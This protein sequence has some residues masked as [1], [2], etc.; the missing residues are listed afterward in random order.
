MICDKCQAFFEAF[1]SVSNIFASA[2]H[3]DNA[4]IA[5]AH[6]EEVLHHSMRE[7]RVTSDQLCPICRSIL[8]SPTKWELR[9]L[10]PDDDEE[11]DVVLEVDAKNT[12]F[13][14]LFVTFNAAG[15]KIGRLPR[16]M[17]A[18]CDGFIQDEEL[19][20]ALGHTAQLA[21]DSTGS[22]ASLELAGYWLKKCLDHHDKC[23]QES[24]TSANS[25]LPT[26]LI[27]VA[28]DTIRLIETK[29]AINEGNDR[30]YVSLSHCWGRVQIIRTLLKNIDEHKN[31]IDPKLLS[32]TFQEAIHVTRKLGFRY[33]WIDSL[34]IIQDEKNDWEAEAGTM[35]DVYRNATLKIAAAP[36]SGGDAGCFQARDGLIQ[37]PFLVELPSSPG[38][39][40]VPPLYGRSWVL[41]EQLL[42]PRMLIFDGFQVRWQCNTSHGSERTP[43]GG[44]SRHIGH[45][46]ALRAGIFSNEEFFSIPDI[47][48]QEAAAKYQLQYWMYTV[49]DYTHRGMTKV[50]D[51]LVA[52]EG[53]AQALSRHTK[54][55]YYAG[56]WEQDFWLGLLW[57]VAHENEFT[58]EVPE[59][60]SLEHNT[61]VRHEAAIAPSWSWV[62]VTVPVVYP[63]P[64][65]LSLHRMCDVLSV[66]VAGTPA[67][68]SGSLKLTGHLRT[69]YVDAIY[70][71]AIR[72]AAL[73]NPHM[74]TPKPT[75]A[76]HLITYRGRSFHPND[77]FVFSDTSPDTTANRLSGGQNWRLIRGTFRPDELIPPNTQ[78]TFL[79]IA[80]WHVGL[81][82]AP[83]TTRT[84]RPHDPITIW[85]IALVPTGATNGEFRRVGYAVWEDCAWYGYMCGVRERPGRG[86]EREAGWKG[87]LAGTHL[88]KMGWGGEEVGGAHKHE[89]VRG[90]ETPEL[91]RYGHWVE[92][93]ERMV[94][95]V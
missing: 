61:H 22:D 56:L 6:H 91:K 16:R 93:A 55:K 86:V 31:C 84:H 88:E 78:L 62:S 58:A 80:Q 1:F 47:A 18:V 87:M 44:L 14:S 77:F 29:E 85:S 26:R 45:Q 81:A 17:L 49:M 42:S 63:V 10:V 30:R 69:G 12:A 48:S 67:A 11:L 46:K 71:F 43:F 24:S 13:P 79:A 75:G 37:F 9:D 76:K 41:Q 21:N 74:T 57:S 15:G 33:V 65:I 3:N 72:D 19:G 52:I 34:C 25:W 2:D 8:S 82:E 73:S 53:I 90:G 51:R 83:A 4:N 32:K 59:A 7:L 89:W 70:P 92:V 66:R 60:F 64:D 36:A 20:A 54:K 27:D 5:W 50:S 40:R 28:N 23:R 68:K 39:E 95:V 38:S 94:T 35:C